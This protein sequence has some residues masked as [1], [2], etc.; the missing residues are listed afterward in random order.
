M[1]EFYCAQFLLSLQSKIEVMKNFAF[2]L[3]SIVLFVLVSCSIEAEKINY[4]SDACHFCKMT[5][6]DKQHAA[7]F[8]SNKGKQFKFDAIECMLNE[9]SEKGTDGI[10]IYL[11]SDYGH[12]ESMIDANHAIYL[13]S[14][15]IKSPMGAFL[16]S[17]SDE[18]TAEKFVK[19]DED[20]LYTWTTIKE[21]YSIK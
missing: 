21:K 13:I 4:G 20:K 15:E 7:Q 16:S 1:I 9:M 18:L 19:T 12:P 10:A 6:V 5:I 17:F 2:I 3:F 8:V 14:P 11:V